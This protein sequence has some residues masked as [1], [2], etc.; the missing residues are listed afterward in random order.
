M[1]GTMGWEKVGQWAVAV[2]GALGGLKV[3]QFLKNWGT[4]SRKER[5][6]AEEREL[7]VMRK[8]NEWL[9]EQYHEWAEESKKL[10]EDKMRLMDGMMKLREA[11][12]EA[13]RHQCLVP[14]DECLRRQPSEVK[15]RLRE[16]LKGAYLEDHPGAIIDET[17]M[18]RRND[19]EAG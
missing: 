1:D 17:D 3:F 13:E 19:E 12:A 4:D 14:D 6:S 15:C 9:S 5:A 7:E 16:L 8:H 11:L 2:L 18:K 10:R